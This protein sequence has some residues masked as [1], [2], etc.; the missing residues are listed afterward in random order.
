[1]I[2]LD[3]NVV[4]SLVRERLDP[5]LVDWLDR[6]VPN[7]IWTTSVTVFEL[8]FGIAR[9]PPGRRRDALAAASARMFRQVL[10][11]RIESFDAVAAELAAALAADRQRAGRSG[12]I[13]DTMIAGIAL[14]RR[15]TIATRNLRHFSDLDVPVIDPWS[16]GGSGP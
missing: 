13:R 12:D 1:M 11:G 8:R 4:S 16:Q 7:D 15:A 9:M 14:A 2:L 6:Q 10:A 3:T 5:I